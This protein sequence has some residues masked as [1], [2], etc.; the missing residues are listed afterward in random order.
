MTT[1]APKAFSQCM[2][3]PLTI[4][5]V[6]AEVMR[7]RLTWPRSKATPETLLDALNKRRADLEQAIAK[8][9]THAEVEL[10][11]MQCA[12]LLLRVVEERRR[13]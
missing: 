7:S 9:W 1:E 13:T 4:D 3:A 8:G 12:A 11:A 10:L 5:A 2:L 6:E